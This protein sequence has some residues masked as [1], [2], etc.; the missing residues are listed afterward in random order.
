[1]P[2]QR[3]IPTAEL[4]STSA[5]RCSPAKGLF[6]SRQ[7]TAPARGNMICP[8]KMEAAAA[9]AASVWK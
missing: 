5:L 4:S 1:M 8:L 9:A 7:L 3:R 2:T 6:E